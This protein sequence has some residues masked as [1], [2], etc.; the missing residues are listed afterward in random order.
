VASTSNTIIDAGRNPLRPKM[1]VCQCGGENHHNNKRKTC[2][3]CG[4]L[5]HKQVLTAPTVRQKGRQ[6]H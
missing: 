3:V 1:I 4:Q 5:L 6:I 2:W